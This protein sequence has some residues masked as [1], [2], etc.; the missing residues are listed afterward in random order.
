MPEISI[1]MPAYNT[2]KYI[3]ESI[4]SVL[5]QTFKDWE[6]IIINDGSPD[7]CPAIA[8]KYAA[9]DERIRVLNQKN[10]G[11]ATAR[12]HGISSA[13][14]K[15][16]FPLDSDDLITPD[17]LDVL[18]TV[19]KTT[20]CAVASPDGRYFGVH[21]G[22]MNLPKISR[23]NMYGAKNGV[24][25]SS[26]YEKKH[27]EKY[28]GY[29]GSLVTGYEDYE[30]WMNF[31]DDGQKMIRV[32]GDRFFYR[33]KPADESR[34][35]QGRRNKKVLLK[36][37]ADKHPRMKIPRMLD[38][39]IRPIRELV[40]RDHTNLETGYRRIT[41]F[42]KPVYKNERF[43]RIT[44]FAGTGAH[45]LFR[46]KISVI[47]VCLNEPRLER[48]CE[49]IAA[50]TFRDFEWIVMDGGSTNPETLAILEKYRGRMTRFVSEKDDGIYEAMNKG[51][52]LAS[53]RWINFMNG[54]DR[55]SSPDALEKMVRALDADRAD[56]VYGM[57]RFDGEG[58]FK[59]D[60][61]RIPD[62]EID[63]WSWLTTTPPHPA[64][65]YKAELFSKYGGFRTDFRI[66]SD[67]V[68]NLT[69]WRKGARYK[70]V[71]TM[72]ADFDNSGVSSAGSMLHWTENRRVK[73]EF[74]SGYFRRC[75][76]KRS[77]YWVLHNIAIGGRL[78]DRLKRR[79]KIY[80]LISKDNITMAEMAG[81]VA[82]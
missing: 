39:H 53:G 59:L 46:P 54:G 60:C 71:E 70:F 17:C 67:W 32:P 78:R 33:I 64:M 31:M 15:Y 44:K 57:I 24:H 42:K 26:L 28:G 7:D 3:A 12:N 77:L 9:R 16:I 22:P 10:S 13:R 73:I 27:W 63:R 11:V 25:N 34:N 66:V 29:D 51:I 8:Q 69:F 20:G 37:I 49:S 62:D 82:K 40:Y 6:L 35:E 80:N 61:L 1:I 76:F 41:I 38:E 30:F 48:T 4:D 58:K 68:R 18:L 81:L 65:F 23:L 14:G 56:I 45:P 21:E 55:F 50:Q 79:Y 43:Y 2:G 36:T 75:K 5:A 72:V 74:F 52:A 47:T 19:L